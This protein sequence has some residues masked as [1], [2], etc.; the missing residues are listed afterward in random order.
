MSNSSNAPQDRE[1]RATTLFQRLRLILLSRTSITIGVILLLGAIAGGIALWIFIQRQLGPLIEDSL[2]KSLNRPVNVGKLE[3]FS[4]TGAARFGKS[5]IP[6]TPTD[7]DRL[8][9]EAIEASTSLWGLIF[10]RKLQLNIT[11]IEPDVY[12]EQDPNRVWAATKIRGGEGGGGLKTEIESLNVVQGQLI[13]VPLSDPGQPRGA[14]TLQQVNG[15]ANFFEDN[16]RIKFDLKSLPL[17]GGNVRLLGDT[18]P[19]REQYNLLAL[20]KSI[21]ADDISRLLRLKGLKFP[22]GRFSSNLEVKIDG[23]NPVL[24]WG[25]VSLDKAT[26]LIGKVPQPFT[27]STG[28]IR[29]RSTQIEI[30]NVSTI[31]GELPGRVSGTLDPQAGFNINGF[32][33]PVPLKPALRTL[34]LKLPVSAEAELRTSL[35]LAGAWE[36]PVLS[37]TAYATKSGR[38]DR[39]NFETLQ[40]NFQL[41]ASQL[42]ITGIEVNPS[43]GGRI[44]G[45]GQVNLEKNGKAFF[46]LQAENLPADAIAKAYNTNL[47]ISLGRISGRTQVFGT[48][49]NLQT[50]VQFNAPQAT[51]PGTGNLLITPGGNIFFPYATFQV[52]S[53]KVEVRGRL[54]EKN[55]QTAVVANNVDGNRLANLFNGKVP[56]I[57]Q[58]VIG[59]SFL[60]NG[61]LSNP[62]NFT[63]LGTGNIQYDRGRISG[64]NVRVNSDRWQGNFVASNLPITRL[65]PE[66]PAN[67][68][69]GNITGRFNLSGDLQDFKPESLRGTGVGSVAFPDG[70]VTANSLQLNNGRWQGNLVANNLAITRISP[71]VPPNLKPGK[72]TGNFNASGLLAKIRPDNIQLNGT[73]S[74]ALP[75]GIVEAA[76][77][78][79]NNGNWRGNFQTNNLAVTRLVPNIAAN[80]RAG[81]IAGNFILRG[82]VAQIRPDTIIGGGSG[83]F[84]LPEGIISANNLQ[85]NRGNWQGIFT[86]SRLA[87][88]NLVP[89]LPP[90]FRP[91]RVTGTFNLAGN[92]AKVS[93]ETVTGTGSGRFLL[94]NGEFQAANV[95][96]NNGNFQANIRTNNLAI[97][98]LSPDVSPNLRQGRLTGNFNIAGNIG[99]LKP[100]TINGSGSGTLRLPI[101]A[102]AANSFRINNGNFQANLTTNNLQIGQLSPNVPANLR[103]GIL[104]GNFNIAGN[105]TNIAPETISSSGSGSL[106]LPQGEIAANSFNLANGNFTANLTT[107]NLAIGQLSP[108]VPA[109]LKPG[110]LTGK[111]NLAGNLANLAPNRISGSGAGTLQ[112]P[113]GSI[114][115]NSFNITNGNFRANLT[116]NNLAIAQL[117]PAIPPNLR[118]GKLTGNFNLAGNLANLKP[119]AISG[120]GSG[121]LELASGNIVAN[122]FNVSDGNFQANLTA[123]NLLLGQLSPN[124]PPNLRPGKLTGNFNIAGN[125]A[126]LQP[127]NIDGSGSG[128]L[129]L[130]SGTIAANSVSIT[131][132]NWRGNFETNNLLLGQV[133]PQIPSNIKDG[134]LTAKFSL[135]G[136]LA[137]LSPSQINGSGSGRLVL[138]QGT[139]NASNVQIN[140]GRWRGSVQTENLG[141]ASLLPQIADNLPEGKLTANFN[142]AGNLANPTLASLE[143]S[144][145]GK[146]TWRDGNL[147]AENLLFNNGRWQGNLSTSNLDVGAIAELAPTPNGRPLDLSGKLNANLSASGSLSEFNPRNLQAT[148]AIELEN[149]VAYGRKFEPLL[150]GNLNL[151]P[152]Q[153]I[154]LDLRGTQDRIALVLSPTYQPISF[155]LRQSD[156]I[157]SGKTAGDNFLI[158]TQNLPL[159]LVKD[160]APLPA[161]FASQPISGALSGNFIV[162]LKTQSIQASN[163]VVVNP[164]FGRFRGD[165]LTANFTYANG[166]AT[167]TDTELQQGTNRYILNASITP[168]TRGPQFQAKLQIPEGDVQGILASLQIFELQDLGKPLNGDSFG[169]A[170]NVPAVYSGISSQSLLTQIRRLTEIQILQGRQETQRREA[171]IPDLRELKGKFSGEINAAGSLSEGITANFDLLGKDWTWQRYKAEQIIAKGSFENGIV[172]LLP[173]RIESEE[174]LFSLT[175]TFGGDRQNGQLKL[176]NVPAELVQTIFKLPID[177]A[178]KLNTTA[179]LSGSLQN[180][181]TRGEITLTQGKINQTPIQTFQTSFNYADANLDFYTTGIISGDDPI[182][183]IGAIPYKLPFATQIPQSDRIAINVS[184]QDSALGLISLLSR[185]Q[186]TWVDGKG[187]IDLKVE[188]KIEPD[189][190]EISELVAAGVATIDNATIESS[191]LQGEPLT[192]V[193]GKVFFDFDRLQVQ[194]LQGKFSQGQ[195]TA[196]GILPISEPIGT[197]NPLTVNLDRLAINVKDRYVGGVE[198]Q[199]IVSRTLLSPE[200]SGQIELFDGRVFLT[201]AADTVTEVINVNNPNNNNTKQLTDTKSDLLAQEAASKQRSNIGFNNLKLRLGNKVQ[202]TKEPLLNF[203]ASGNLTINGTLDAPL[204]EGTVELQRGQVNLFT[205]QFRLARG[206]T[207]TA[208]FT[209]RQGL[210]PTLDVRLVAIVPETTRSRIPVQPLSSEISDIPSTNLGSIRTVRIEARVNGRADELERSLSLTSNPSR[211]TTEIVTLLGGGFVDTLGQGQTTLG[212]A[213]LAG[214]A[215]LGNVQNAIGDTLGLSEFRLFPTVISSQKRGNLTLGLGAEAGIDINPKFSLSVLTILNA[216]QPT[217][218]GIRYRVNDD[219]ILRGSTDFSGD[220]RAVFEYEKRF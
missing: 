46:N 200:I 93:P 126:N 2:R 85:L 174:S 105:L 81:K 140:N 86:T 54:L 197:N 214:S 36:K 92:L 101:G 171:L 220:S 97:A 156:L 159:A 138:P 192:G 163:A 34:N 62:Q 189:N 79:L 26:F 172:T 6:P 103:Q 145:R 208:V 51:Y 121:R 204:P 66:T 89:N 144:G 47:P 202:I 130:P 63:A 74:L 19:A 3:S 69:A 57:F 116:T 55:W 170:S 100:S 117:S 41:I 7:T 180:P 124:V 185:N 77:V 143:G 90:N 210:I 134:R 137:N 37:G 18:R 109:N 11:L 8:T 133:A 20:G 193:K 179:T 173:L 65:S 96:L 52:G 56:S 22:A 84:T 177:I 75:D 78:E 87:I 142:L 114:A 106:Q 217:Q 108:N 28:D 60:V 211:S 155:Y 76:F 29:F 199:L 178:G 102:I 122:S 135:S 110:R 182:Q 9:V 17:T 13:L 70:T 45:A 161:N 160:I 58:G 44:S 71:L 24:A 149:F 167:I 215:L 99:N 184:A 206:Y 194:S 147:T 80:L 190:N 165:K 157:A 91:G 40:A 48:P 146:L 32:T 187:Q 123:N 23:D 98:Q 148:G 166:K 94:P 14:I 38:I 164:V 168:T 125:L 191:A 25:N 112:L 67:L 53:G 31:Y 201:D 212:L 152:G 219:L 120:S 5:S 1:P 213:N 169:N 175:G 129:E 203:L 27:N 153:N 218:F 188:G 104:T 107:N 16:K 39:L 111:F 35:R 49:G 209:P 15:V 30:Q 198:G 150:A 118:S 183:V 33:Y 196:A 42:N 216:E 205:T 83:T 59:G 82:N 4:W 131:N 186:V 128:R 72:I 68:Q 95:R 207:Q 139:V 141:I 154:N 127:E 115:A 12:L 151:T 64:T 10:N 43:L 88:A 181:S 136:D 119:D 158:D 113:S 21:L 176:E 73:G 61:N 50:L 195:V 162:N 132:G